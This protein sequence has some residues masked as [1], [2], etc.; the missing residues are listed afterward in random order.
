MS[1][2]RCATLALVLV[3]AACASSSSRDP[4]GEEFATARAA[5]ANRGNSTLIVRAQLAELPGESVYRAIEL[6]RRRWLTPR[7][8]AGYARVVIDGS[9]R[10][11]LGQLRA[12]GADGVE[13]LRYLSASEATIKYGTGY[14]GGA[15]EVKTRGR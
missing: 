1:F 12:M 14:T 6:L 9:Y 11:D 13:E 10:T 4:F 3:V 2:Q 5:D 8:G 15:I 7:R